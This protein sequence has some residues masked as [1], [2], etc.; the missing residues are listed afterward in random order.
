ME[1]ACGVIC[2]VKK[3][4]LP[5]VSNI[6]VLR[7]PKYQETKD[8]GKWEQFWRRVLRIDVGWDN[9]FALMKPARGYELCL[10]VGLLLRGVPIR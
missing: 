7:F 9:C 10:S 3:M 6:L 2:L 8:T 1:E 4:N 5:N